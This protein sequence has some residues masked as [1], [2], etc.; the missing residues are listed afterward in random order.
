[1]KHAT[2]I[3]DGFVVPLIGIPEDESQQKCESCGQSFDLLQ[4]RFTDGRF[5][6]DACVKSAIPTA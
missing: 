5:V 1:M 2:A 4:I 3:R 6:C